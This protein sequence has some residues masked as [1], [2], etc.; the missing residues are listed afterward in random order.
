CE[1]D[2]RFFEIGFRKHVEKLRDMW[3][4]CR[5]PEKQGYP[6]HY[7]YYPKAGVNFRL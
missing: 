5:L 2:G 3:C 4:S 6:Y 7:T 1:N